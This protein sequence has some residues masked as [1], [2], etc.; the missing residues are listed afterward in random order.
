MTKM[1]QTFSVHRVAVS[2]ALNRKAN[3]VLAF[4]RLSHIFARSLQS[5]VS[6]LQT[7]GQTSQSYQS[8]RQTSGFTH[9]GLKLRL[10]IESLR[11]SQI[12]YDIRRP[13]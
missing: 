13:L 12:T 2:S 9:E 5:L 7:L 10:S 11:C 3:L 1:P 4:G 8:H 6:G